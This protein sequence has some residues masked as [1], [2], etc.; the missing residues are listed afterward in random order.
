MVFRKEDGKGRSDVRCD[1][2][3]EQKEARATCPSRGRDGFGGEGAREARRGSLGGVDSGG[4]GGGMGK[5]DL[6]RRFD[7]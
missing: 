2:P 3:R 6:R 1:E 7:D 5:W 4:V